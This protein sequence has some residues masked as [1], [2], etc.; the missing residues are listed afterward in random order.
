MQRFLI[1]ASIVLLA[2]GLA[3][4]WLAQS[5][6]WRWIGRM[7]GDIHLEREGFSF[8][9]PLMTCIIASIIITLLFWIF[10]K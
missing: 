9:V 6:W 5:R 8:H 1:I 2:I 4:P 3:W 7:P 10:R